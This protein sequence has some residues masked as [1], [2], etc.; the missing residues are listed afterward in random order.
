MYLRCTK[1]FF[2]L[3]SFKIGVGPSDSSG[4]GSGIISQGRIRNISVLI[5]N[6]FSDQVQ[7]ITNYF[8]IVYLFSELQNV[9]ALDNGDGLS[10]SSLA[11]CL[12]TEK[13]AGP[14]PCTR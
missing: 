10:G 14:L 2:A 11:R 7:R 3:F 12:V 13:Y 1:N 4:F 8:S 9:E 6:T 5:H